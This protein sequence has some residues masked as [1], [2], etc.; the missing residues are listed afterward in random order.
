[1]GRDLDLSNLNPYGPT[2]VTWYNFT[3]DARY[4][5]APGVGENAILSGHVD[6]DYAVHYAHEAHYRGAGVFAG[7]DMLGPNDA[8][9]ITM[10]GTTTRYGVVWKKQVPQASSEWSAIFATKVEE[11]DAITLITCS[12]DFNPATL[13]YDQR[14]VVRARRY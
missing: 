4:G 3:V 12:G 11:G 9:E 6:Y 5:G 14:T 7:I 1:V 8:I 13:E 2:D 10:N